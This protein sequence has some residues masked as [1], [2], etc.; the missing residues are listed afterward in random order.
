MDEND[1]YGWYLEESINVSGDDETSTETIYSEMY[2]RSLEPEKLPT[3]PPIQ[4][5]LDFR[6][7]RDRGGLNLPQNDAIV[8][9]VACGVEDQQTS[10][11][12]R[13]KRQRT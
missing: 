12:Q 10:D 4:N 6:L 7:K 2:Y 9:Q 1:P 3:L 5:S 8:S 13:G 11:S